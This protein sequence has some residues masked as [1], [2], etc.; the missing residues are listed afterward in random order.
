MQ[1]Q[2]RRSAHARAYCKLQHTRSERC[3]VQQSHSTSHL[4]R[5][6]LHFSTVCTTSH[7]L[8]TGNHLLCL[9][10]ATT[11][12]TITPYW[13]SCSRINFQ[14]RFAAR[15]GEQEQGTPLSAFSYATPD[16]RCLAP[17]QVCG[18]DDIVVYLNIDWSSVC[19]D[20]TFFQPLFLFCS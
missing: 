10:N 12:R 7:A 5:L 6:F 18:G 3:R 17:F 2:A 20:E 16:I 1:L 11:L 8:T 9:Q 4:T 14:F 13:R 19:D 15:S